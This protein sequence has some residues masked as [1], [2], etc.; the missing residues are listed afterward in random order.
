MDYITVGIV[1]LLIGGGLVFWWAHRHPDDFKKADD[2]L[3]ALA[4]KAKRK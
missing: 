4:N 2:A 1:F 3:A